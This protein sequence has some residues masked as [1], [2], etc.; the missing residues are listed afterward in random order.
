MKALLTKYKS[1]IKFILT[2]LLLYAVLSFSY[3]LYLDYSGTGNYYP[4]FFTH[5]VAKQSV[6][7]IDAFGY[8]AEIFP[9]PSAAYQ[10][11]IVNNQ[12][13]A[14]IVEGCNS[15]SI[16]ILFLSFIVAFADRFKPT[17][18]Y[19]LAGSILLYAVN[20]I[21]IAAISVGLYHYPWRSEIIHNVI[22]PA[23]IY[24]MVLLLWVF[25]VRRFSKIKQANE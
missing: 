2:F 11:L 1:V 23:I 10:M 16:I 5:L 13:V 6:A 22:F 8:K 21:R 17:F 3:K 20:L 25:W 15:L 9:Y 19:I 12:Y 4:D 24:G 18:L 14:K 7:I